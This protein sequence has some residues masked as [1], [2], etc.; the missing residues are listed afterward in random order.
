MSAGL[1]RRLRHSTGARFV[2]LYL[3]LTFLSSI[4][5]FAFVYHQADRLLVAEAR[6]VVAEH[7]NLLR[8]EYRQGGTAELAESLSVT[9]ASGAAA[10]EAY[11]LVD[12]RG[13]PLSGNLSAWPP[14]SSDEEAWTELPLYRRGSDRP[15]TI[16]FTTT[17]LPTG[18]RLLVGRVMD[19]R[20]PLRRALGAALA[21]ALLLAIPLALIGSFILLKFMNSRVAAMADAAARVTSGDLRTRI[22]SHGTRDPFDRLA[23]ALNA[24]LERLERLVEELRFVTDTLAHDLRSPLTRMRATLERAAASRDSAELQSAAGAIGREIDAMLK[25]TSATIEVSRAEAGL[26]RDEF[27]ALDAATLARDLCELY[28]PLAAEHGVRLLVEAPASAPLSGHQQLLGQA[29]SNLIDNALKYAGSGGEIRLTVEERGEQLLVSVADRGPG[30]P[31]DRRAEAL[32][33]H[34][35]LDSARRGD[36]SGLGLSLAAA[37]ARLHGGELHLDDNMP[38]LR[39]VLALPKS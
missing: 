39:A 22:V 9:V 4:P 12:A 17:R 14:I 21:T 30:I 27:V 2:A 16:G 33:R 24:M 31:P 28:E 32:R 35:R 7:L 34:G 11:L 3:A 29:L 23:S 36:G 15:E 37:V 6:E 20:V 38:G 8:A 26:G 19:D 25:M 1:A 10:S 13:T 18:H 5:L